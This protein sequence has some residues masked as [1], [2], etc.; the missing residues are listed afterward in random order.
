MLCDFEQQFCHIWLVEDPE[1]D[2]PQQRRHEVRE[3]EE[4][5]RLPRRRDADASADHGKP[6]GGV[7]VGAPALALKVQDQ[8]RCRIRR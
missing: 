1:F 8:C 6:I 3:F 7:A 5:P 4:L 2:R